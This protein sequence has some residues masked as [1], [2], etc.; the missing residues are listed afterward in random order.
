MPTLRSHFHDLLTFTLQTRLADVLDK[1]TDSRLAKTDDSVSGPRLLF[2]VDRNDSTL[3][4]QRTMLLLEIFI[5]TSERSTR[6][7]FEKI[8]CSSSGI[9]LFGHKNILFM[10]ENVL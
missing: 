2:S 6:Q 7:P 8:R 4:Q 1:Q 5:C 9:Q 3:L 10:M